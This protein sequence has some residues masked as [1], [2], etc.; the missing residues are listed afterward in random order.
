MSTVRRLLPL[1]R[2]HR[3]AFPAIIVLGLLQSL[4]EGIG[5]GLFLPLLRGLISGNGSQVAAGGWLMERMDT[6][7]RQVPPDHRLAVIALALFAVVLAT[8]LLAYSHDIFFT[9]I[10]GRIGHHLRRTIFSQLMVMNFG[11]IERDRSGRLL[12]ILASDTWRTSEALKIFVHLVITVTTVTVYVALLLLMSWRLTVVVAVGMLVVSGIIRLFTRGVRE[13]GERVVRANSELAHRMVEGLDGMRVI[14]AYGREPH[15]QRRFDATSERLRRV[16]LKTGYVQGAIHPVHEILVSGL[17]L[18][19]LFATARTATDVSVLL[20]FVFVLYRLQPRVKDFEASR[21]RLAAL[22]SSVEE[23]R[24]V[25]DTHGDEKLWAS[26][27]RHPGLGE[28][29]VFDCVT[30]RYHDDEQAA[31]ADASFTIP[32]GKTTAIVGPSGGGKS[33]VIKLILRFYDPTSGGVLTDGRSLRDF[34]VSSWRDQI[35]LVSQDGF[36]FDA[37]VRDNI[38]YGKLDAS[39]TEIVEAARQADAHAFIEQLPQKYNTILGHR[40]VRLSGGEQQRISLARAI[41]RNPRIFILDEAT[42][43]L[44][45]ISE[46]W[47]QETLE[48][49][50]GGR[51]IVM[52]AHRLTTIEQADQ[53]VVLEKGRVRERGTLPELVAEGG[54][55]ARMYRLQHRSPATVAEES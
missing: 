28:S 37:T 16:I 1:L 25:L 43:A 7:F 38:A 49:L 14:R 55:F 18:T 19:V 12:N 10:D 21:V 48:R 22:A 9:W 11:T 29:I 34:D 24:S 54:L 52:I 39:D 31:L 26:P 17:L 47:I 4:S 45:S 27:T 5:I 53:I 40:G 8:A 32:A 23:V 13:L 51:T 35:A 3:W 20:V 36:L 42:N 2:L 30:F 6:V 50:R 46:S 33:T 44:D 15:E 41:V